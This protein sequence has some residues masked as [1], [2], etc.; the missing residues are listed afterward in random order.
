MAG[1]AGKG[2]PKGAR[3]KRNKGLEVLAQV[4]QE[5][6]T[7]LAFG[8]RVMRD[9][10]QPLDVRSSPLAWQRPMSMPSLAHR[11]RLSFSNCRRWILSRT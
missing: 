2:R 9:A 5:G 11:A 8:L 3:N 6:E 10:E 1:N 7:P 4:A